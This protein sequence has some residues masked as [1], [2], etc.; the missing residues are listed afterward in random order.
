MGAVVRKVPYYTLE[1]SFFR[2]TVWKERLGVKGAVPINTPQKISFDRLAP[3]ETPP[4]PPPKPTAEQLKA[5]QAEAARQKLLAEQAK[6]Q[7]PKE[8]PKPQPKVVEAE[9]QDKIPE[10]DLQD[11]PGA[12]DK[13]G[14][15]VAAKIARKW[16][17]SPKHI[18]N[19]DPNSVQP[20]DDTTVTL[21]W[22][23]GFG[24][25][26]KRYDELIS[27]KIYSPAA[28]K[29]AKKKI[30]RHLK[31]IFIDQGSINLS[32][33]TSAFVGDERQFHIDWQFQFQDIPTSATLD[34][35][36]LTDLTA[37]LGNFNLYA[38]V[39]QVDVSAERYFQ[40]DKEKQTKA[41][42]I[43]PVA[44]IT[45]IYVYLKDN[46]SF[47]DK[48]DGNSQYLGHWNKKDM[49]LSYRA[50]VSDLIDGKKVHT[51]MG[52]SEITETTINWPYLPGDP[53]DKPVDK[54]PGFGKLLEKNVYYPVYNKTY[55]EWREKHNRGGDFMIYSKPLLLKLRNPISIRLDTICR[56]PEPM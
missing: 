11:V 43:D 25:V 37:A 24:S 32:F 13:I 17:A 9:D 21:K 48:G 29:E 55:N 2:G 3:G 42:C 36:A 1:P 41:Y 35:L 56:A 46:Y 44:T 15:P 45:H 28:A 26:Q 6:K 19:D 23:L 40:Y 39:G 49:I 34:G 54:R 5:Q 22:A 31:S 16:F 50:A 10:F 51:Q 33:D 38:A 8:P 20:I 52:S 27:K 18:Y 12:M 30:T 14:W 53:I 7:Q 47:N 4:P